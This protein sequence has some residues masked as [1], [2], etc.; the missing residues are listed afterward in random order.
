[1]SELRGLEQPDLVVVAQGLDAQVGDPG[2]VTDGERCGHHAIVNL[3]LAGG[4]NADL[5]V[6]PPVAGAASVEAVTDR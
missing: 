5:G 4:S 3:P 6:D 2:E 1:V